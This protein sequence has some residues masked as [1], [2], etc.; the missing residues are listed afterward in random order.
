[1]QYNTYENFDD[2]KKH[3]NELNKKSYH[4]QNSNDICTPLD[5]VKEMVDKIPNNFWNK[6]NLKIFDS[7]CGNGNF[8]A[9]IGT[10]TNLKN[11]YFNEIN[12]KRIENVKKYFGDKVNI[13]K[14]DFLTFD[15][16]EEYD[17]VVSNPPYAKI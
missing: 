3:F 2:I 11:L 5:C 13:T 4:F 6:K 16:K 7:C 9:Y 10:K 8:H 1:M 12:H 14:E 15:E 17:L